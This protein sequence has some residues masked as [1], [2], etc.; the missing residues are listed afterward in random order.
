MMT[1]ETVACGE[2]G[3]EPLRIGIYVCHCG[4]NIAGKV[5]VYKLTH[6]AAQLPGVAVAREYKFMCSEPGQTMIQED[7]RELGLNRVV[8]AACSPR[9]HEMTFRAASAQAGLNPYLFTQA[10]IREGCS[11]VTAD[12]DVA[13]DKARRILR[14]AIE[15]ARHL[16]PLEDRRFA[17]RPEVMIVGAGIAGIQAALDIADS[18][19]R[20]YL[21]ER[22]ASIG[23]KMAS[24]DKTF[25]TLDCSSCIL[26]PKMTAVAQHPNITLMASAE[27]TEV[28]GH[29]GE[30]RVHVRRK[31][32]FVDADRCTGCGACWDACL[33][34]TR[35]RNRVLK[36]DGKV[37]AR[38]SEK[39]NSRA[40]RPER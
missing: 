1:D 40:A 29:V 36:F 27:V 12:P 17:V 24:I 15:R 13:L 25:P 4:S 8:V 3:M 5:D 20:V 2:G 33:K 35:P 26:T 23:G 21:V 9:M 37:F 22:D 14:G 34:R 32:T 10:N 31:A 18:G 39:T 28:S 30:F 11:W 16:R 7:I 19:T 38:V 6:D